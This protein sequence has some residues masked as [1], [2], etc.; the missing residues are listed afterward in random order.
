MSGFKDVE[1]DDGIRVS[2]TQ[3]SGNQFYM[4]PESSQSGSEQ[5][6]SWVST[7][8]STLTNFLRNQ[9]S[10]QQIGTPESRTRHSQPHPEKFSG[11]DS[12]QYPQF[13]SL[14]E[15]K[16]K[17]DANAIGSEEERV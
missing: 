11:L 4:A 2:G 5:A 16:L 14:L 10:V 3:Y 9:Q 6:P 17:I 7:L 12:S 15:A 1:M 8:I 13:R